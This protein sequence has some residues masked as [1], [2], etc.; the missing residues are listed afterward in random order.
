LAYIVNKPGKTI[1]TRPVR[2]G[3][4]IDEESRIKG[5]TVIKKRNLR[6]EMKSSIGE[7]IIC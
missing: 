5:F 4:E 3:Y 1:N 6:G 2:R 7:K